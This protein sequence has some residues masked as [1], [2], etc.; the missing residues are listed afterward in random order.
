[1][2]TKLGAALVGAL[3]ATSAH[4]AEVDRREVNQQARIEQGVRSGQLNRRE[5]G[6]LEAREGRIERELGRDRALNGGHLTGRER[7]R[8]ERQEN[9]VS[10]S[11]YADKHNRR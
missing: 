2:I 11:I 8:I 1:M 5:A 7:A 9:R 10:R 4:A 3:L 6:R